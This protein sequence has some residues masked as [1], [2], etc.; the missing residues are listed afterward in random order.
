MKYLVNRLKYSQNA[1]GGIKLKIVAV[2]IHALIVVGLTY[3]ALKQMSKT[4]ELGGSFGGGA[5][6]THFGRQK[7]LDRDGKITVFLGIAFLV[8]SIWISWLFKG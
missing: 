5:M 8:S 3:Y 4:V 6:Y 2:I 1:E 7:G